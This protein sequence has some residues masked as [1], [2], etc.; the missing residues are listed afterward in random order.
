M[1]I[2]ED[3]EVWIKQAGRD[4]QSAENSLKSKD[5]YVAALLAQQATE[6]ALKYLYLVHNKELL[7]IHDLSKLARAVEAPKEMVLKCSE[8]NPVYIEVRYPLGKDMPA[9]KVSEPQ[10]K[11]ILKLAY[12]VISWIKM[13]V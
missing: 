7:R 2:K 13:Q 12:E 8:I 4:M 10:A 5:Y 11:H 3:V 6:K 9:E 1:S